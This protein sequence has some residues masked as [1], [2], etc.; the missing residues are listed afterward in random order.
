M[1]GVLQDMDGTLLNNQTMPPA[2]LPPSSLPILGINATLLSAVDS[3][4]LRPAEC[5]YMNSTSGAA[6][7]VS[8]LQTPVLGQVAP[9]DAALCTPNI[10]FR[11][12]TFIPATPAA[13]ALQFAPLYVVDV[14][15]NR[16]AL[17]AYS[18]PIPTG[19]FASDNGAHYF[20]VPAGREYMVQYAGQAPRVELSAVRCVPACVCGAPMLR[21]MK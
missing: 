2:V 1:Q 6:V 12:M 10:T 9:A 16:S 21:L 15:T 20:V 4:L 8:S 14:A 11:R 18:F 5:I 17:A 7:D 3:L 13:A 19:S